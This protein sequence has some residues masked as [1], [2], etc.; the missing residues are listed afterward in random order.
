MS[1]SSSFKP[2]PVTPSNALQLQLYDSSKYTHRFVIQN[3]KARTDMP[4]YITFKQSFSLRWGGLAVWL[5]LFLY[6]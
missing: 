2:P 3:G 1:L 4:D 6:F 5:S